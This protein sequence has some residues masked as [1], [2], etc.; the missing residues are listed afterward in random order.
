MYN[1]PWCCKTA[2]ILTRAAVYAAFLCLEQAVPH[3][4]VAMRS[5]VALDVW[6][7]SALI[8]GYV[9]ESNLQ[10]ALG[11]LQ[12]MKQAHGVLPNEV[13]C[14]YMNLCPFTDLA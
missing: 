13:S 1:T 8:K 6:S 10:A 7:Y 2:C 5:G 4:A 3:A 11:L 9:Q 14:I 12:E